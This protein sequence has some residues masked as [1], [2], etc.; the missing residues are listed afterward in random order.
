MLITSRPEVLIR[1]RF[2]AISE[3]VHEDFV[4]H[5]IPVAIIRYDITVFLRHELGK[6]RE[7]FAILPDWPGD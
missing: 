3:S 7:E 2:R 6:I 4:L 1:L 5:K